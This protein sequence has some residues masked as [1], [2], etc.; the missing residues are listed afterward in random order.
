MSYSDPSWNDS[1]WDNN[2]S[3]N[4]PSNNTSFGEP[5]N[6]DFPDSDFA[7][8]D[9]TASKPI[10]LSKVNFE[11][12]VLSQSF[13]FMAIALFITAFAAWYTYNSP[14][15][16]YAIFGNPGVFY[17][18]LI[19]E[20]VIVL[21]NGFTARRGMLVPSAILF[22]IYSVINGVTLASIFFVYTGSSI[23]STFFVTAITFS[24]MAVYGLVTKK[25]LTHIGS[26]CL[27]AL[28]GIIIASLVNIFIVHSTGMEMV[29]TIL[30]LIIFVGL[31]AYDA[32]K[33]KN[34][35]AHMNNENI[36]CIA[37]L[38]AIELYLD[39]INIFLKL[40]RLFGR[41]K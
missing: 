26:L 13:V 29:I 16:F 14:T 33:I 31:T 3:W 8:Y 30:G 21:V 41:R 17:G 20:L 4:N 24:I 6:V 39:F 12:N 5:G 18:L 32:Q 36:T 10:D 9:M 19:S 37:L 27:M 38:G 1:N 2:S 7:T 11:E 23:V 15:L 25:D 28:I 34:M 40:L 22:T 35:A